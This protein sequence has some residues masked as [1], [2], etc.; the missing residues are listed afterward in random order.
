MMST[1]DYIKNIITNTLG[2]A[3]SS[4]FTNHLLAIVDNSAETRESLMAASDRIRNRV[5]LFI[6]D[7]LA[8]KLFTLLNAELGKMELNPGTRRKH[9]RVD[10]RNKVSLNCDGAV[11]EL[12]TTN[13][14]EG[15]MNVEKKDPLPVGS[16]VEI[17]LSLKGGNSVVIK[18][19]V[20]NI[21]ERRGLHPAGMGIEF[22]EVSN[23]ILT[24]L[25]S[26]I[27]RASDQGGSAGPDPGTCQPENQMPS[28]T[29]HI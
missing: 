6:D 9:V 28:L 1:K 18:G 14:S 23:L 10:F 20:V 11:Y 24:V 22:S 29:D 3:A 7:N 12:Y 19:V 16:R 27:K 5:A 8:G 25:K 21:K 13:I 4:I 15:G 2:E 26:V 17:S